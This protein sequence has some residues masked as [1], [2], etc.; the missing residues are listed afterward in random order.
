MSI[1]LHSHRHCVY[2]INLH[3]VFATKYRRKVN[4]KVSQLQSKVATSRQNW[5][6]QVA[7]EIV[8]SNSLVATEK[9]NI[10][11]MTR[12]AKPS[13]KRKRQKTGRNRSMLDVGMGALRSAIEY[14]LAE[15]GGI[16]IEV[17]TVKVKPS[18]TCP[19]C[20]IQKKKELSERVH[21][22]PCGLVIDRDVAAAQVMLNWV[23]GFGRLPPEL[24]SAPARAT[25]LGT[26]LDKR[27]S[28][29][30]TSIH[31]GGF[32]QLF[33]MKRQKPRPSS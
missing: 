22:C 32:K 9:L 2:K 12:K 21:D 28:D 18:Q 15:A 10:K 26:K 23:R 20:G 24:D 14:K 8:S 11:N 13:S 16:F 3:I 6:H 17:P 1:D 33:E 7:A 31:C 4:K 30:S 5:V 27:G 29:S 19:S 25:G